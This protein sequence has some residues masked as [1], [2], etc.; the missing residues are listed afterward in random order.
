LNS[1]HGEAGKRLLESSVLEGLTLVYEGP[2]GSS[3]L[4]GTAKPS[5]CTLAFTVWE[6]I[7]VNKSLFDEEKLE[8]AGLFE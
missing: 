5:R 7:V 6:S 2:S 8:A 4:L 3:S 1:L